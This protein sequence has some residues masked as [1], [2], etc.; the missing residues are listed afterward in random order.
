MKAYVSLVK[1]SIHNGYIV[2][3]WDGEEWQVKRSNSYQEI[4][5]AI[6]SVEEAVL[7]IRDSKG[8]KVATAT[9]QPYGVED[10]ETVSDWVI[11]PFMSQWEAGYKFMM[12]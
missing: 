8:S 9:V 3:V 2:S 12:A 5:A 11:S 6:T 10:D 7:V 1:Y 4:I